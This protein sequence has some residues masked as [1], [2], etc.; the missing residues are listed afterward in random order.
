MS[1]GCEVMGQ[2]WLLSRSLGVALAEVAEYNQD[3]RSARQSLKQI[4]LAAIGSIGDWRVQHWT[5]MCVD[6]EVVC[7]AEDGIGLQ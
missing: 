1:A 2:A 5:T 4:Q 3:L 6:K 7:S